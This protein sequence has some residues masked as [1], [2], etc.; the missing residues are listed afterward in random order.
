MSEYEKWESRYAA[1]DYIFGTEPNLFLKSCADLL[2]PGM[3]VLVIADGEGRNG[4]WL[5]ERGLDVHTVD[6]SPRAVTKAQRL[7]AARGVTARIA[8]ADLRHWQWPVAQFDAVVAILVQFAEPAFRARMFA[9]MRD[10]L[11]P[12]GL[13]I[14][15]GYR[16]KQLDYGTGGPSEPD[17]FYTREMLLDAFGDWEVLVLSEHDSVIAEGT[18]HVGMSALIDLAVRKPLAV[19]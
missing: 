7:A 2:Q 19:R 12:G 16:P 14:L 15:Q 1:D 10:A 5:A 11:N 6:F 13:V 3:K 18:R 17:K 4:V 8:C 9:A